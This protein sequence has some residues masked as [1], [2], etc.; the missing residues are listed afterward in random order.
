MATQKPLREL[1]PDILE[2][3]EQYTDYMEFN[4]RVYNV[5]EGQIKEEVENSL[6]REIISSAALKRA[7][8]RIPPI[9]ILRKATKKLSQ[10]YIEEPVRMADNTQDADI[11][12]NIVRLGSLN[13]KMQDANF[14]YNAQNCV[15][16]EPFVEKGVIKFRVLAA[17]Q[18]L[19]FSDDPV[20]PQNMTVGI[21][22]LGN[23]LRQFLPVYDDNGK[24]L[25]DRKV[26][27]VNMFALYTDTEFLIINDSGGVEEQKMMEMGLSDTHNFGRIPIVYRSKSRLQLIPFPNQEGFDVSVL[28]PKLLTDMNYAIQFMAHS[29]IW[30]RN[31]DLSGQELNPDAIVDLGDSSEAD[32]DPEIGTVDPKVDIPNIIKAVEY[33]LS[34][35]FSSVG[36]NANT[37]GVLANGRDSSAIGKAIDQGD[38]T[39]SRKM[40]IDIFR[41]FE[42]D[43]MALLQSFQNEVTRQTR[44]KEPRAFSQQFSDTFR[45]KYA[46]VK[47][48][49]TDKQKL[50]E[51]EVWR[52]QQLMSRKQALREMRP[53]MSET[54]IEAWLKEIEDELESDRDTRLFQAIGAA[55]GRNSDGTFQV[56]NTEAGQ[57]DPEEM[58][59]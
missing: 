14:I 22:F 32:G 17:H 3:I 13:N 15:A 30:T 8:Q 35:Y 23:E 57:E 52:A 40:Q 12:H 6:R 29:I 27:E 4:R 18:F 54:Q 46:E 16:M 26:R 34:N 50:D 48:S 53:N 43:L 21:K 2:H 39:S 7:L 44:L 5:V 28:V 20:N 38:T 9:N 11:M 19:P 36:I 47:I 59:G 33:E 10:V 55:A 56:D 51:I 31:T 58:N 41:D 24:L 45:I 42:N 49:K 25:E 1:I 37:D